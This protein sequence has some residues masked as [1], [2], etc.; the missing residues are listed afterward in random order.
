MCVHVADLSF[1]EA[2]RQV[3]F[4]YI[5]VYKYIVR[6]FYDMYN[7]FLPLKRGREPFIFWL[8]LYCERCIFTKLVLDCESTEGRI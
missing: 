5:L 1:Y 2:L 6:S 3:L 4:S 7:D 8:V